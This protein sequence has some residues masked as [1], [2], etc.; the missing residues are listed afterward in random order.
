V[1]SAATPSAPPTARAAWLRPTPAAKRSGATDIA[2]AV[3]SEV[4]IA[5]IAAPRT[6]PV[7]N[8]N[9]QKAGWSV[10]AIATTAQSAARTRKPASATG[11]GPWRPTRGPT[12]TATAAAA[13][14]PGVTAKP[15]CSGE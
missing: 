2:A 13:I 4:V 10:S 14:A 15:A 11:H 5:P 8:H 7:G 1:D 9:A 3:E 6:R 12:E